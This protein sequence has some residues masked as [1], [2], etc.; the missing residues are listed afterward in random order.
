MT[1]A[2]NA[3]AATHLAARATTQKGSADVQAVRLGNATSPWIGRCGAPRAPDRRRWI[4]G[5]TWR[6]ETVRLVRRR[7]VVRHQYWLASMGYA[8]ATPWAVL[9]GVSEFGGGALTA[10]GL[11]HPL[12]PIATLGSMTI[13]TLDVHRGH[14]IWAGEG[15]AEL[16]VTNM[17]A[18]V[19]SALAGPGALSLDRAVGI[20]VPRSLV[21]FTV[22]GVLAGVLI[23]ESRT[24]PITSLAEGL[25]EAVP[26][27]E[28]QLAS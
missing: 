20:R 23:A 24:K 14:P 7:R 15:G 27:P 22:A 11:M 17:A 2:R 3:D 13:A 25:Q 8:P 5:R 18:A 26:A 10:L 28:L 9:S 4:T 6:P 21:A 19:A 12:G 16:P 1:G